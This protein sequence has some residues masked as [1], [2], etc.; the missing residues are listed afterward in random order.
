MNRSEFIEKVNNLKQ[1]LDK[2]TAEYINTNKIYNLND[3]LKV[4]FNKYNNDKV[5]YICQIKNIYPARNH[6]FLSRMDY[7]NG[8]LEY[9]AVYCWRD[10]QTN[11]IICGDVCQLGYLSGCSEIC[12]NIGVNLDTVKIEII[13]ESQVKYKNI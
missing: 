4:T 1:Q 2:I 3:Y 13:D 7:P 8:G 11:E 12:G 10:R 5:E 6:V 9:F